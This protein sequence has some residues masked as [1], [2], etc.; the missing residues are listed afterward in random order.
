MKRWL[1][2]CLFTQVIWITPSCSQVKKEKQLKCFYEEVEKLKSTFDY[3]NVMKSFKDTLNEWIE[4]DIKGVR[5]LQRVEWKI[6]D[7]VFFNEDKSKCLL[8]LG[9]IDPDTALTFD[10]VQILGA[11]KINNAWY[12][13]IQSYPTCLY[14]RKDNEPRRPYTFEEMSNDV[15]GDLIRDGY[16]RKNSCEINYSYIDSD[17]WFADWMRQK[18]KEFLQSKW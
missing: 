15:V 17:I 13:Y 10:E 18:H 2:I 3:M 12:F 8:L 6:S 9:S 7:V 16:F 4:K 14:N 11:E 1:L 5:Y